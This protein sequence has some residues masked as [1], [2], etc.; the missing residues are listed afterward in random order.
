MKKVIALLILIASLAQGATQHYPWVLDGL[1]GR[2]DSV[3]F[4]IL[5]DTTLNDSLT[6]VN[7]FPTT[8]FIPYSDTSKVTIVGHYYFDGDSTAYPSYVW[9]SNAAGTRTGADNFTVRVVDTINNDTVMGVSVTLWQMGG[10]I[11]DVQLT[12]SSGFAGFKVPLDS[13]RVIAHRTGY[14]FAED[15]FL[16]AGLDTVTINGRDEVGNIAAD[17]AGRCVV[18]GLVTDANENPVQYAQVIFSLPSNVIFN[19]CDSA[20]IAT[21]EVKTKTLANGVFT[22]PLTYS[23][24]L[25]DKDWIMRVELTTAGV[26]KVIVNKKAVTV[27]DAAS[28]QVVF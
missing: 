6:G 10:A 2:L 18:T 28:Y 27:P 26:T 3:R 21:N 14:T 12:N 11:E 8:E 25:G 24:C 20:L 15:S 22:V 13:F 17:T 4:H 16:V 9:L 1:D 5:Q 7:S 23:S 19:V